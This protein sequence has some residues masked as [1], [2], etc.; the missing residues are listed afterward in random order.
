M[1]R[2]TK[3]A[4]KAKQ[5]DMDPTEKAWRKQHEMRKKQL[6]YRDTIRLKPAVVDMLDELTEDGT[7]RATYVGELIER[8]HA[9]AKRASR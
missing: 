1:A 8:E 7:P 6:R 3:A 4:K 9:K 2:A 5:R